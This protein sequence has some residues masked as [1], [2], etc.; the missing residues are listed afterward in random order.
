LRAP[1]EQTQ[2]RAQQGQGGRQRY[3]RHVDG[4]E[5]SASRRGLAI[6]IDIVQE[7]VRL[8]RAEDRARIAVDEGKLLDAVDVGAKQFA[9]VVARD[10]QRDTLVGAE[11]REWAVDEMLDATV[12]G[13]F[14][15]L[16]VIVEG[17]QAFV[18]VASFEVDDFAPARA[19]AGVVK[20]KRMVM[21]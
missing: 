19:G 5:L 7:E 3:C 6:G 8:G 14:D 15:E 1:A 2:R 21:S 11:D 18:G 10:M 4:D 20:L 16:Q 17:I 9:A 12:G 13:G